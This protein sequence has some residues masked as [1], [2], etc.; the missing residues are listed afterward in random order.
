MLSFKRP[1]DMFMAA[2]LAIAASPAIADQEAISDC[3]SSEVSLVLKGCGKLISENLVEGEELIR[4]HLALGNANLQSGKTLTAID[5]YD[6]A[7]EL[8]GTARDELRAQ[9]LSSRALANTALKRL[10]TASEDYT[11]AVRLSPD[12]ALYHYNRG[13]VYSM[14]RQYRR[15]AADFSQ[16]IKLEPENF[17]AFNARGSVLLRMQRF[18]DAARDFSR[19][20]VIKPDFAKTYLFRAL[21]YSGMGRNDLARKDRKRA[22]D[23]DPALF[24]KPSDQGK[25]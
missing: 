11:E 12:N 23:L 3:R 16:T 22:E 2:A 13:L 6:R 15:A 5:N 8:A 10:K 14:R 1:V 9:I 19:S 20:A 25:S 24:E 4:A 18:E 21:A 7:V 17:L